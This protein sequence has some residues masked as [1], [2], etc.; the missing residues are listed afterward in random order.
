MQ[1]GCQNFSLGQK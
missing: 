1:E